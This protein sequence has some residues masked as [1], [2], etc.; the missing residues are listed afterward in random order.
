[1]GHLNIPVIYSKTYGHMGGDM[2]I[3]MTNQK[4]GVGKTTLVF[5]LATLLPM[6]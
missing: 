6:T 4:G 3:V 5:H 1:M 2:R